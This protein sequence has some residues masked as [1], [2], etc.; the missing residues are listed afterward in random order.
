MGRKL[1]GRNLL[2]KYRPIV[3]AITGFLICDLTVLALN[4]YSST[5]AEAN[6]VLLNFTRQ[7]RE[8]A[9]EI[10]R[11]T[12]DL[13]VLELSDTRLDSAAADDLRKAVAS[14]SR[15]LLVLRDGGEAEDEQGNR[16]Y[17]EPL[18]SEDARKRLEDISVHWADPKEHFDTILK[19]P[20]FQ[21]NDINEMYSYATLFSETLYDSSTALIADAQKQVGRA[22]RRLQLAQI[23][24]FSLAL[25]NFVYT[26]FMSLRSLVANDRRL[27]QAQ[28]ET[29]EIL[30][31][32]REGLF[33]LDARLCIGGKYSASMQEIFREPIAPGADFLAIL[34]RMVPP[35][36]LESARDYL[37]LLFG[38]RVKEAL[39]QSLNPLSEVEV[40]AGTQSRFLSFQFNRV[41]DGGAI[42]HL[43]VTVQDATSRVQLAAELQLAKSRARS[44][45]EVYLRLFGK[46]VSALRRFHDQARATLAQ[47]ND[48][49]RAAS[50][51]G[52]ESY[53]SLV[54]AAFRGVHTI[55]G[56]AA[57]LGLDL[58]EGL[59]HE[60]ENELAQLRDR[61]KLGGED[62]LKLTVRLDELFERL[63]I[64][65]PIIQRQAAAQPGLAPADPAAAEA[66][67]FAGSIRALCER[68]ARTQSKKVRLVADLAALTDAPEP[69]VRGLRELSLQLVRNAV[70]HGIE[71]P[72]ERLS[73]SKPETGT[74]LLHCSRGES[75]VLEFS[76]RDDGR[77]LDPARIRAALLRDGRCSEQQLS[78]LSDRE[79]IMKIFE[80]GFSTQAI[81]D[82]DSGRGVGL[83]I[84]NEA[85]RS[86]GGKLRLSSRPQ[87]FTEFSVRFEAAVALS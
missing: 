16:F 60:F 42:S 8:T 15:A 65:P 56:E 69:L 17:V 62:M 12:A 70:S 58:F 52:V 38:D 11:L 27:L 72:Q 78:T 39:V 80:P 45:L 54:R 3:L 5:R 76:V 75:G 41:I 50:E 34:G 33:L 61:G 14:F 67:G 86:L 82:A 28:Q 53:D 24:G 87:Q 13:R 71:T 40:Q 66:A 77:G 43:L 48:R 46:D 10:P 63:A 7:A 6:A 23:G 68:L 49:L 20:S 29:E 79:V 31:N 21:G 81:A 18:R 26:M 22:T 19:Q 57:A 64:L 47:I 2:G 32:V 73:A 85:V 83:D 55:K 35:A 25:I 74:V 1:L 59:A 84:V 36:T 44:E 30:A 4:L 9:M 37:Q 51:R